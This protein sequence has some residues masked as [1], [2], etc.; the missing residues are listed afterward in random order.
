M[1]TAVSANTTSTVTAG[2]RNG[3]SSY[4]CARPAT[5][6]AELAGADDEAFAL[7]RALTMPK[8]LL[9][10]SASLR[11]VQ[12]KKKDFQLSAFSDEVTT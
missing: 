8:H 5:A 1:P 3:S 6:G 9:G 7:A 12:V 10:L 2:G 11:H 4:V